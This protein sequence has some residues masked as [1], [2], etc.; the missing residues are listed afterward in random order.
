MRTIANILIFL[1][2]PSLY[3]ADFYRTESC[4]RPAEDEPILYAEEF[5]GSFSLERL[6]EKEQEV[7]A[8]GM[9][10]DERAYLKDGLIVLPLEE[11]SFVRVPEVFIKSIIR[12]VE[13]AFERNYID[14]L[15]FP[16]MGHS[17]L[18]INMEY[19][20]SD[21][22]PS[23]IKNKVLSY[24]RMFSHPD[25]KV[26]YH[27]A[28]KV[29]ML[30]KEGRLSEDRH[31]QWRFYTRNLVGDNLAQGNV[32][33]I[34]NHSQGANTAHD[35]GPGYRYWGAGFNISISKDG[36]FPFKRNG[37]TFYFDLS[38]KDLPYRAAILG[39]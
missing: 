35:Y 11:D 14:A 37:Q 34:F 16:D 33:F 38:L 5:S 13:V 19:Y 25:T 6:K 30:T 8:S 1:L 17:H 10:L 26:L 27:T 32:N 7:Y 20:K 9:R 21:V 15:I 39:Y 22:S 2:I 31:M 36:C 12:H 29:E 18:F 23:V 28:E 4:Q 3:A 24:E